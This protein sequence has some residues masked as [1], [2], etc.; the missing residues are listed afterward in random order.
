MRFT[1]NLPTDATFGVIDGKSG[2]TYSP[3]LTYSDFLQHT[4]GSHLSLSNSLSALEAAGVITGSTDTDDLLFDTAS[5]FVPIGPTSGQYQFA[6]NSASLGVTLSSDPTDA[7]ADN[8]GLDHMVTYEITGLAG[9]SETAPDYIIA[10][11]DGAQACATCYGL[12][13]QDYNDLVLEVHHTVDWIA[14]EPN[15]LAVFAASL[16]VVAGLRRAAR[17]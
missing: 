13:D 2:G 4:G 9:K 5:S 8:G 12:N 11:E 1:Q 10:F 14:P 16:L 7:S 17:N 15:S 6:I 3:I